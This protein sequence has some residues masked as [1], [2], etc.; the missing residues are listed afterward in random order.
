MPEDIMNARW[1]NAYVRAI[2]FKDSNGDPITLTSDYVCIFTVKSKEKL[3]KE[4]DYFAK[5]KVNTIHDEDQITNPGKT[6]LVVSKDQNKFDA[7]RYYADLKVFF[8]GEPKN[9]KS[10]EYNLQEV[11][12]KEDI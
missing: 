9:T 2:Y 12:G 11:V 5:V 1:G 7:G 6:L 8:Q 3:Q 4:T 10:I